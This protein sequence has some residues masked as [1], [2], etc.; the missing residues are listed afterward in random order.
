MFVVSRA[1]ISIIHDPSYIK[2]LALG[3]PNMPQWYH[4]QLVMFVV[5]RAN[6]SII[7]DPSYIKFLAQ[8]SPNISQWYHHQLVMFVVSRANISMI[9]DPSYIKSLARDPQTCPNGIIINGSC[10]L[11][12]ARTYPYQYPS[13]HQILAPGSPNMSQRYYHQ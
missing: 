7:H 3:S 5:S 8:G 13:I 6:I 4:H 2:F 12:P 10:L 1:N 9:H 11:Y